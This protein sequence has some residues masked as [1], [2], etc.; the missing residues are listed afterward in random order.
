MTLDLEDQRFVV[1]AASLDASGDGTE[2]RRKM[3]TQTP[4][5]GSNPVFHES[6]QNG[7]MP[8]RWPL[9]STQGTAGRHKEVQQP[10]NSHLF[11]EGTHPSYLC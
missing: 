6:A 4:D 11:S 1:S 5:G 8:L 2:L 3:V 9:A 7:G 10:A